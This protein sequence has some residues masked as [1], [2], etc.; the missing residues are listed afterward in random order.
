[1]CADLR[2]DT[3]F[4]SGNLFCL[5]L[6]CAKSPA[7]IGGSLRSRV[8]AVSIAIAVS[9]A[10]I[11]AKR[12][13]DGSYR[14]RQHRNNCKRYETSKMWGLVQKRTS[15]EWFLGLGLDKISSS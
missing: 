10:T 14:D 5:Y 13:H 12:L 1:M 6:V 11:T 8:S 3:I 9:T 15:R 4:A 2:T 7:F